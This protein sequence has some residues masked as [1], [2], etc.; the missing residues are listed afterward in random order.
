MQSYMLRANNSENGKEK[1]T[2]T[3]AVDQYTVR[4]ADMA[5]CGLSSHYVRVIEVHHQ[6]RQPSLNQ[7]H[8]KP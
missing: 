2:T 7:V 8:Q 1:I 6:D 3:Y 5:T 4:K